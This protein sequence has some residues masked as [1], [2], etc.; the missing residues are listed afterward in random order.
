MNR[1][2]QRKTRGD[3]CSGR[4]TKYVP[5]MNHDVCRGSFFFFFAPSIP[6]TAVPKATILDETANP[7][8][9]TP[10]SAYRASGYS[11]PRMRIRPSFEG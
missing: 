8:R 7:H 4:P 9:G 11:L 1:G 3:P 5:K 2:G 10:T 6:L